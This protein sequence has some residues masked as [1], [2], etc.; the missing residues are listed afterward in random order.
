[1]N[2]LS[3]AV[4][5]AKSII[6]ANSPILLVGTA[7]AG[8]VSTGVLAAMGGYK[9]RGIVDAERMRRIAAPEPPFDTF[10]EYY[11]TFLEKGE[12]LTNQEKFKLTWLCYAAPAVT[13]VSTIASVLGVH[14]IHTKRHAALAGLYAITTNKLDDYREK[15]EELLGPK[16]TQEL[17]EAVGQKAV[18]R[19]PIENSEVIILEGGTQ[20][21]FD[22]WSGRYFMGS[23]PIVERA[24]N[25]INI[26]LVESGDASLNDFYDYVGLS[27][28][29][30]GMDF[31]WSG[32]K[33]SAIF[34]STT[35]P[36]GRAA[37]MFSFRE[38]PKSNFGRLR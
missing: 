17:N 15:A 1:M 14:V 37:V 38:E 35:T 8:V 29:P 31:G 27:P 16:K 10:Q 33:I 28:I 12:P 2:N 4:R 34:T 21:C 32:T 19:N 23:V 11:Q 7:I 5:A 26:R 30:I 18:D 36:D 25:D 3:S 9:A 6:T 24:I 13:G 20:L 22:D